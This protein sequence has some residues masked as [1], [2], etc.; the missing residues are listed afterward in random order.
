M[1]IRQGVLSL[2]C[3]PLRFLTILFLPMSEALERNSC[4]VHFTQEVVRSSVGVGT[5]AQP[6]GGRRGT[7]VRGCSTK[8]LS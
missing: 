8:W 6:H 5:G 2:M 3:V 4:A 7:P 1:E